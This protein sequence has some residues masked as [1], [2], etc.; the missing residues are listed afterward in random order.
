MEK[1]GKDKWLISFGC[2]TNNQIIVKEVFH[3]HG[4][5]SFFMANVVKKVDESSSVII[6]SFVCSE[7]GK[8]TALNGSAFFPADV[9]LTEVN[10][11]DAKK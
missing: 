9:I 4:N 5:G 3:G 11:S 7:C 2:G 10:A 8:T 1:D 6:A